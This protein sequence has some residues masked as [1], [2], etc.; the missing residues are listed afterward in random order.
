MKHMLS[1]V[2]SVKFIFKNQTIWCAYTPFLIN[3]DHR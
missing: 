1:S 3:L 2:H